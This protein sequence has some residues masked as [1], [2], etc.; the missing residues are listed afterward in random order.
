MD[1]SKGFDHY[2]HL[3]LEDRDDFMKNF[4]LYGHQL[5]PE[6]L[7][8]LAAAAEDE[9]SPGIEETP[10]TTAQFKEQ[11][12]STVSGVICICEFIGNIYRLLIYGYLLIVNQILWC[13][14]YSLFI[15]RRFWVKS[16]PIN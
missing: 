9:E 7:Q 11:V 13:C 14:Y 4:L 16:Q 3:W 8:I 10:P 12:T 5:T 6:E 2:S 15:F 1:Y